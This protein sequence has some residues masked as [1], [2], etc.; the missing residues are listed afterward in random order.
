MIIFNSDSHPSSP[1]SCLTISAALNMLG[2]FLHCL[3]HLAMDIFFLGFPHSI[4]QSFSNTLCSS[5]F[6]PSD[7]LQCIHIMISSTL[8]ALYLF[9]NSRF[10]HWPS[11]NTDVYSIKQL[12]ISIQLFDQ[13]APNSNC[14]WLN[15]WLPTFLNKMKP[16]LSLDSFILVNSITVITTFVVAQANAGA[17]WSLASTFQ[18]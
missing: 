7:S 14:F 2:A 15:I 16:P 13:K 11:D 8:M 4:G 12:Y 18:A 10:Q 5:I 3:L 17:K 1:S 9:Y 6:Q